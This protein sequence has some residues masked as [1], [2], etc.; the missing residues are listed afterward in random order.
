VRVD[1]PVVKAALLRLY[2]NWP[3]A[4]SVPALLAA[5]RAAC[6]RTD[7]ATEAG[8]AEVLG[9]VLL[10]FAGTAH[11]E[12]TAWSP[13]F[14]CSAGER[15]RASA[16]ARAQLAQGHNVT[17]LRHRQLEVQDALGVALLGL[18]DGTR[19]RVELVAELERLVVDGRLPP[20]PSEGATGDLRSRLADG[21]ERS[22]TGLGRAALL[23]A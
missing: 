4:E 18:L 14:V 1:H 21:L 3:R 8:D 15:P 22:L 16:L 9:S 11:A 17:T 13:P 12:L 19:T 7:P 10:T 20:P 2:R 5:A 6:G 23:E